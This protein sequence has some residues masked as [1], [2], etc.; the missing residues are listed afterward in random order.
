MEYN[1][2]LIAGIDIAE[3]TIQA[4]IY[5]STKGVIRTVNLL[6]EGK[7]K[8]P[9]EVYPVNKLV[10]ECLRLS[11]ETQVKSVC[12]TLP[13]FYMDELNRV[14][15]ELEGAGISGDKW[16]LISKAE[17][18]AYY[19]YSQK[20][21]LYSSGVALFDYGSKGIRCDMLAI[22]KKDNNNYLLQESTDYTSKAICNAA[23]DGNIDGVEDEL[24]NMAEE[25]FAKRPVSSAY[26]TGSGFNVEKLPPKFA[27]LMVIRRKAFVGQNLY[28][29][30]ACLCAL[31]AV[32][33]RI[34][35][36]VTM[37]LDNRV[38]YGIETDIVQYGKDKRFRIIKPGTN[39]YMAD[40]TMEYML[41]DLR[42]IT[43]KI[44]TPDN[45]YYDE[46]IDISEIPFREG[47]TTRISMNIKFMSA[48][49]CLVSIKDMGFGDFFKS[50][51]KVIYKE[52]EFANG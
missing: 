34:F 31:E 9:D 15:D 6:P 13:E 40:R 22:R 51:G 21:E 48:D 5:D 32:K 45:R 25:Y 1:G 46:V 19:A 52:L 24:C 50:S 11:N 30:G 3:K 38:K 27:K 33:P 16:Q 37:L 8:Q 29:K 36:D 17:S 18:F 10:A 12:I 49:R 20:R 42:K 28:C 7:E 26:L 35:S 39:W 14:R 2:G 41:D 43:L 44:I 4:G 47:M 23:S